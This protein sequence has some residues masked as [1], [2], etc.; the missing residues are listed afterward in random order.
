MI[1]V[2]K[3]KLCDLSSSDDANGLKD[4]CLSISS[5]W[6]YSPCILFVAW[7]LCILFLQFVRM[8]I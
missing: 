1:Y 5:C 6:I 7:V 4:I 8:S 2:A 3:K